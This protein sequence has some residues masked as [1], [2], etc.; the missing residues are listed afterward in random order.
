MVNKRSM[1][2]LLQIAPA[3][4]VLTLAAGCQNKRT[5][6]AGTFPIG[7]MADPWILEGTVWSGDPEQAAEG[8]GEDAEP[9]SAFEPQRVWLAVYRHDIRLRHTLVIRA[10]AFASQEQARQAYLHFQPN[11]PEPLKA[12]D[13]GCWTKDGVL[14]LWG[15]MVFDIFGRGPGRLASPEQAVYLWAFLEKRMPP[16]LPLNPE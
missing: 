2:L 16:D 4:L 5:N 15:R 10:W 1:R 9:W 14:V 12:G 3:L 8:V 6:I 13:E 7:G 11:V